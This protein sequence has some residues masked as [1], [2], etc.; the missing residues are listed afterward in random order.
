MQSSFTPAKAPTIPTSVTIPTTANASSAKPS[1][2]TCLNT[3]QPLPQWRPAG[4]DQ[5]PTTNFK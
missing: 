2:F 1:T 4:N 5:S 3:G